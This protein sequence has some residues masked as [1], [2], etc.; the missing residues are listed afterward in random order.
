MKLYVLKSPSKKICKLGISNNVDIRIKNIRGYCRDAQLVSTHW[1]P[2][3]KVAERRL[4][5]RLWK[6]KYKGFRYHLSGSTEWYNLK[7]YQ[8]QL[9]VVAEMWRQIFMILFVIL[10]SLAII[11]SSW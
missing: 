4:R 5:N 9:Q 2:F 8:L 3:P 11:Y 6:H 1:V 7:P 10:I